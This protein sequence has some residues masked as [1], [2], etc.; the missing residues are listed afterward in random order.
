MGTMSAPVE[1]ETRKV[2]APIIEAFEQVY[3][4]ERV[5]TLPFDAGHSLAIRVVL[6][7]NR[8]MALRMWR[9]DEAS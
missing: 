4:A 8:V 9:P 1:A 6:P 7:G 3:G 5:E 2:L